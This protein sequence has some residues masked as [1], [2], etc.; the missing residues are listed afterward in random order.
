MLLLARLDQERPLEAVPVDLRVIGA[1]T[2]VNA[3]RSRPAGRSSCR[4]RRMPGLSS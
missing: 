4:S 1:D 3:Q 2:V